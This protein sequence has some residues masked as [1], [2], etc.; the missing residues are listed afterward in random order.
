MRQV[1]GVWMAIAG[2][3][4][5][6][7]EWR[8]DIEFAKPGG[9]SLTLDAS[10]PD[11]PG[12]F[13]AVIVVHGG[14]WV[15]GTKS[16][17]VPPLFPVLTKAGFTWFTINYRLAPGHRFPAQAEDVFAAIRWVRKNAKA[18]KVDTSRIAL[19]GESAGGHLVSYCAAR[20]R[21]DTAVAAAIPFYGVHDLNARA[22]AMGAI[23]E[24]VEKL[25]NISSP[26]PEA[27][28]RMREA[29]PIHYVHRGMPPFLMI[30]GT[31][32]KA[33]PYEQ[34]PLMCAKMKEAG[35]PCE[36]FRVDGAPHGIGPWEKVP[37][38]QHYKEK[39]IEWLHQ[40]LK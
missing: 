16:S 17:Y 25:L 27:D 28:A 20:G 7:A 4:L 8:Q 32:D 18:Y 14:G 3:A 24:N 38:F 19:V 40:T 15:N 5:A 13:P 22:K 29:S 39:M 11:G 1:L 2:L 30:H 23:G 34:S 21:G 12:P 37:E 9:F 6:G 10:V 31:A 36:V 26:G 35:V 33:V